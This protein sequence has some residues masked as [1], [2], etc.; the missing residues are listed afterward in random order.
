MCEMVS[1]LHLESV[2]IGDWVVSL[3][4]CKWFCFAL[5]STS[6]CGMLKFVRHRLE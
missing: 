5:I 1:S 6:K 4:L 3:F 2:V